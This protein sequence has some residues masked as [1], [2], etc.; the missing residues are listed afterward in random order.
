LTI[1]CVAGFLGCFLKSVAVLSPPA[2]SIPWFPAYLSL[3]SILGI[4]F[5]SGLWSMRRWGLWGY[6]LLAVANQAVYLAIGQGKWIS[7]VLFWTTTAVGWLYY[8]YM[9]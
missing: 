3:S 9:R 4:V 2:R 6:S 1:L 5:L 7:L 8:R